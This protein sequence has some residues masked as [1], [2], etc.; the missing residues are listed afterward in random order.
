[1][2]QK[3]TGGAGRYMT[4]FCCSS[5][6]RVT[7]IISGNIIVYIVLAYKVESIEPTSPAEY[8]DSMHFLIFLRP[9]LNSFLTFA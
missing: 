2:W 9:P 1:M 3:N 8:L 5:I 4:K 6:M 7:D